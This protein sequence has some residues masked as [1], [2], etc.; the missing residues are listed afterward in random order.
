MAT[1]WTAWSR[2][3]VLSAVGVWWVAPAAAQ[4]K[5][6][7]LGSEAFQTGSCPG[8]ASVCLSAAGFLQGCETQQPATIQNA[9]T[10]A[11]GNLAGRCIDANGNNPADTILVFPGVYTGGMTDQVE[12]WSGG[13]PNQAQPNTVENAARNVRLS[14]VGKSVKMVRECSHDLAPG[15]SPLVC[16]SLMNDLLQVSTAGPY[17][18]IITCDGFLDSFGVILS[19]GERIES[20]IEGFTI[21]KCGRTFNQAYPGGELSS[22]G[23]RVLG[24]NHDN[25]GVTL[26]YLILTQNAGLVGAAIS[27]AS[28]QV[29]M[30][31]VLIRNN[32]AGS[33]GGAISVSATTSST[34]T[35]WMLDC[36]LSG[37]IADAAGGGIY[38]SLN[39]FASNP[40]FLNNTVIY[41]NTAVTQGGG[42]YDSGGGDFDMRNS[43]VTNNFA[44]NNAPSNQMY[45]G[46]ATSIAT[47]EP[48][49]ACQAGL[50]RQN[51]MK[52]SSYVTEL[53]VG[54]TLVIGVERIGSSYNLR[55]PDQDEK[56]FYYGVPGQIWYLAPPVTYRNPVS[57][58]VTGMTLRPFR[59]VAEVLIIPKAES[60]LEDMFSIECYTVEDG[61]DYRGVKDVSRENIKCVEWDAHDPYAHIG[62]NTPATD[63]AAGLEDGSYCRNPCPGEYCRGAPWCYLEEQTAT[64]KWYDACIVGS[65]SDTCAQDLTTM[66][67]FS[68]NSTWPVSANN[69]KGMYIK[70]N[71]DENYMTE[72]GL[73]LNLR[74][75]ES[76]KTAGCGGHGIC[77]RHS[78]MDDSSFMPECLGTSGSILALAEADCE[79]T[80]GGQSCS[81]EAG[82]NTWGLFTCVCENGWGGV[83][84][85]V[86]MVA[87]TR[88]KLIAFDGGSSS[89]HVPEEAVNLQ[90]ALTM[91]QP[92]DIVKVGTK[93]FTGPGNY[94]LVIGNVNMTFRGDG[95]LYT[96]INCLE[97]G[98]GLYVDSSVFSTVSVAV[99]DLSIMR[100]YANN[101]PSRGPRGGAIYVKQAQLT[102]KNVIIRHNRADERGGGIY[103]WSSYVTLIDTVVGP[104]NTATLTGGG[105]VLEA[106]VIIA[107]RSFVSE[108]FAMAEE[109]E[110]MSNFACFSD[111]RVH[112]VKEPHWQKLGSSQVELNICSCCNGCMQKAPP[113]D[114][115]QVTVDK[116]LGTNV[117][118]GLQYTKVILQGTFIAF[119]QGSRVSVIYVNEQPC[120]LRNVTS[121]LII[122]GIQSP[123][124]PGQQIE[125]L[126]SDGE[127]AVFPTEN[128]SDAFPVYIG[129]GLDL[130]IVRNVSTENGVR[131]QV[132]VKL[133]SQPAASV[134]IPVDVSCGHGLAEHVSW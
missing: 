124:R 67:K 18:T 12:W 76:C 73:T 1:H 68:S 88:I 117:S 40:I 120:V 133:L 26:R 11:C 75:A 110:E 103:A 61:R 33:N 8:G 111:S 77:T 127:A 96:T 49:I 109:N 65:P 62:R 56:K 78:A 60:S 80:T 108:N 6:I 34:S 91:S 74:Y 25:A 98:R 46:T 58:I 134:V 54:D 21:K 113:V 22:G 36:L 100:C 82:C 112:S 118:L 20:V 84:C 44:T 48:T 123:Y 94:D 86:P 79:K 66:A 2:A 125:L 122:C 89:L 7:C 71:L 102:V 69:D 13:L 83:D 101:V 104:N 50:G 129:R 4:G 45:C 64:G 23:I 55:V 81:G 27:V 72:G 24:D 131:S 42:I 85:T 121:S 95:P 31:R 15:C 70:L 128:G 106:S 47:A 92:N 63:P 116:E 107:D 32:H 16:L 10:G 29:V 14:F 28:A 57:L 126:R 119:G 39:Q 114:V 43:I 99:E 41:G 130:H 17:A 30:K 5:F 93:V 105:I 51:D 87:L 19:N 38:S 52:L 9:L 132:N 37:N 90:V 35:L 59:D 97:Q 115:T 3:L 53:G